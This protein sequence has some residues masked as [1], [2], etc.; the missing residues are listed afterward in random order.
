[1]LLSWSLLGIYSLFR[2][3]AHTRNLCGRGSQVPGFFGEALF[4][5][6]ITRKGTVT[7]AKTIPPKKEQREK[8]SSK[9]TWECPLESRTVSINCPLL[10]TSLGLYG[11][12][13][14]TRILQPRKTSA[15]AYWASP[16]VRLDHHTFL[17]KNGGWEVEGRAIFSKWLISQWGRRGGTSSVVY[18]RT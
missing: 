10:P 6:R 11:P 9:R 1:M 17:G 5:K 7:S 13:E 2:F 18:I 12:T 3:Q 8:T 16:E 15:T 14:N 4:L